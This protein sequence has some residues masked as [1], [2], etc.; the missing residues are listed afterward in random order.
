M[1]RSKDLDTIAPDDLST[2]V[3][4]KVDEVVHSPKKKKIIKTKIKTEEFI[5]KEDFNQKIHDILG[6]TKNPFSSFLV[7]PKVLKFTEQDDHEIIYL[8]VRPHWITN[9]SW[10]FIS[11]AMLFFPLLFGYLTFLNVFP[12]QYRFALVLFWYLIT[13]IYAFEKFL[14]WY[15][16]L[17]LVTNERLVDIDF[18]NL[19]NK[20]FAEADISAIQDVSFSI[21]GILGTF[22]NFG[23]VLIQTAS[24]KN[25]IIFNN[26]ANP[27]KIMR[28]LKELRDLDE[29]QGDQL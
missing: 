16:D 7:H 4:T 23:T 1:T 11:I 21:K 26:V 3:S 17:F 18:N 6:H 13:F 27:Q 24:E 25:Q 15:F 12:I 8:A 5:V 20:H 19:L 14:S 2:E 10:F 28:L 29:H 22:F 9:I